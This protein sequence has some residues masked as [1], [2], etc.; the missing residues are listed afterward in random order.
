MEGIKTMNVIENIISCYVTR[1]SQF[2]VCNEME[3]LVISIIGLIINLI[4]LVYSM[5]V[6][7]KGV[8]MEQ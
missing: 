6:Y 1:H 3:I 8:D 2:W 5:R 7:R 4:L